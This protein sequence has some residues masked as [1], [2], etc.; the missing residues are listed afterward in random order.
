VTFENKGAQLHDFKIDD[1]AFKVDADPGKTA[2]K[3][4]T[5]K[6]GTYA[7]YCD[8]P[9]HRAQGMNGTLVVK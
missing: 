3:T 5:L 2:T 8:I 7:F 4:V 1:P 9:G 6:A